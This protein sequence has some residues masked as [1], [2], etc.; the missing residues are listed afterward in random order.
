[1][2][3]SMPAGLV[4]TPEGSR[5]PVFLELFFD[6][7]LVF[8]LA[9]LSSGLLT[10]LDWSG[11]F[12]TLVLLFA[13]FWVW[14]VT[15]WITDLY[16][17]QRPAIQ[18]LVI[19]T[20]LG[21]LVMAATLPEAFGQRSL[22]FAGTYV[23]IHVGRGTFLALAMRG[24]ELQRRTLRVLFWFCVSAPLWVAGAVVPGTARVMIWALAVAVDYTA[25]RLRYPTPRLGRAPISEWPI[26]VEHLS[27]RYRQ[28]FVI[29]LGELILVTGSALSGSDFTSAEVAA[30][31][32]SFIGTVLSWR[33]Y[34]FRSGELLP[35]A[36]GAATDP[37]RLARSALVAHLL[38]LTGIVVAAVGIQLV[39]AHPT[40]HARASWIAVIFGGPA[41][42][43]IGRARLEHVVF[44]R[45]S[46]DRKIGL[47]ALAA[48]APAMVLVPPLLVSIVGTGVLAG[49]AASDTASA[50][51]RPPEAPAPP[52]GQRKA[53]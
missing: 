3:T 7:A 50:R 29:A 30:F 16:D 37:D 34:I 1:M 36:L 33:I 45:V 19:A 13:L 47:L 11:A 48:L 5:R 53:R 44:A 49:V 21:L 8:A 35:A 25:G 17:P 27:E 9:Q 12:R 24:R 4:R 43:L 15:A 2:A 39:I 46:R 52:S 40:G 26:V 38:M 10:H 41:L 51:G 22:V 18:L 20:M 31:V 23:A 6:L 42:F 32:V 28:V 14:S